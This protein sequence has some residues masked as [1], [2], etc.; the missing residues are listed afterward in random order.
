MFNSTNALYRG[1]CVQVCGTPEVGYTIRHTFGYS[2]LMNLLGV[3]KW[4]DYHS[5]STQ[6]VSI[7]SI[8][9]LSQAIVTAKKLYEQK[10]QIRRWDCELVH[11]MTQRKKVVWF[12]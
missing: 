9:K 12:K 10:C 6:G 11:V 4:E 8:P 5:L 2:W 7:S 3:V 1:I